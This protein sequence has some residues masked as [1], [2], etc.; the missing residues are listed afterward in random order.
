MPGKLNP[1]QL[2]EPVEI[3][4][5]TVVASFDQLVGDSPKM[6]VNPLG[7]FL[8]R[9]DRFTSPDKVLVLPGNS[10]FSIGPVQGELIVVEDILL[11]GPDFRVYL[12]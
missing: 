10:V 1:P 6:P 2:L 8:W 9:V 12:N 5:E 7:I 11:A 3:P 4:L